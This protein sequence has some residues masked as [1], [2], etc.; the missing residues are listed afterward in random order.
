MD[1][2]DGTGSMMGRKIAN[3]TIMTNCDELPFEGRSSAMYFELL[4]QKPGVFFA[5]FWWLF[6]QR[7]GDLMR[8]TSAQAGCRAC[9]APP[10]KD[11]SAIVEYAPRPQAVCFFTRDDRIHSQWFTVSNFERACKRMPDLNIHIKN[12]PKAM[13]FTH[14]KSP[15]THACVRCLADSPSL[16]SKIPKIK[17]TVKKVFE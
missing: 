2:I 6:F 17:F 12:K 1:R 13:N 7:F 3:I 5:T 16:D 9:C 15:F 14:T 10:R 11:G 4:R 8:P